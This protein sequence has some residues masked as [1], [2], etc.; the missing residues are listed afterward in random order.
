MMLSAFDLQS[1]AVSMVHVC[2]TSSLAHIPFLHVTAAAMSCRPQDKKYLYIYIYVCYSCSNVLY[3][4]HMR[5]TSVA[6]PFLHDTAAAMSC[7]SLGIEHIYGH[8]LSTC[9]NCGNVLYIIG[10]RTSMALP[11]PHVTAVTMSFTQDTEHQW[12]YPFHML[13]LWQCL[14]YIYI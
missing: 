9:Y 8:T 10:H 6:I 4:G 14:A 11:F 1:W 3:T 13:L 2:M 7:R 12:P 5:R